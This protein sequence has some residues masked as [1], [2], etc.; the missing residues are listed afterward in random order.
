MT[1]SLIRMALS[2]GVLSVMVPLGGVSVA[3]TSGADR[4]A[5]APECPAPNTQAEAATQPDPSEDATAPEN[6]GTTGWSGGTGG[7][8]LG[9]N[10]QGATD[11]SVTWQPPT[12]RGL[13]LAGLAD[14]VPDC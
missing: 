1:L 9:T 11:S 3:Q 5:P 6:T 13:D 2:V 4:V 10:I 12:A 14:P 8:Q 7:S